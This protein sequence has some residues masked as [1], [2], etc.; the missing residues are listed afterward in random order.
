MVYKF[1][2][3]YVRTVYCI[4]EADTIEEAKQKAEDADWEEDYGGEESMV[5]YYGFVPYIEGEDENDGITLEDVEEND[6]EWDE[7]EDPDFFNDFR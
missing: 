4:V 2:K 1:V 6:V 3:D 7:I 5:R